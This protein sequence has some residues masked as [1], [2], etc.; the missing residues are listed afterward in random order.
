MNF[1]DFIV[2]DAITPELQATDRKAVI[3]ELVAALAAAGAIEASAEEEIVTAVLNRE[4]GGST[5]FGWGVPSAPTVVSQI[6]LSCASRRA[7]RA[8][9]SVLGS[10][11]RSVVMPLTIGGHARMLTRS[12]NRRTAWRATANSA[13]ARGSSRDRPVCCSMRRNRWRTVFGCT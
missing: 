7:T 11:N 10:G 9:N 8:P 3:A 5:G 12:G 6:S 4:Q 1:N 13:T 2:K